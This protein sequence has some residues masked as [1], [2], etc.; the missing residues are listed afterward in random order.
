[1][2]KYNCSYLNESGDSLDESLQSVVAV[3]PEAAA[4]LY[5]ARYPEEYSGI[6][7]EWGSG[8]SQIVS[9]ISGTERTGSRVKFLFLLPLFAALLVVLC[10]E[11]S[12]GDPKIDQALK[13][14]VDLELT[15]SR[16]D[17]RRYKVG[18]SNPFSGWVKRR[19]DDSRRVAR[20]W[21]YKDGKPNG[22]YL[23]WYKSGKK[24]EYG[25]FKDGKQ[26]GL[27]TEL[28]KNGWKKREYTYKDGEFDGPHASWHENGQKEIE[29]TYW[30]V[31]NNS[32]NSLNHPSAED[33][34]GDGL[35]DG[36]YYRIGLETSWHKNGQKHREGSYD[37]GGNKDGPW[38]AWH[39]NGQK[40]IEETYKRGI[41]DGLATQYYENGNKK[42]EGT[43]KGGSLDGPYAEWHENGQKRLETTVKDGPD[44]PYTTWYENGQKAIESTWKDGKRISAKYWNRKG[45]EV[46][47]ETEAQ[48]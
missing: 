5:S 21:Q 45:E 28:R 9:N 12:T 13:E 43:F 16:R 44:G 47:T 48:E 15:E 30:A 23:E 40:A 35:L 25:T 29:G 20:L 10:G 22:L 46:E 18:E 11:K 3:T 39:A 7:V 31:R 4:A 36:I 41:L 33:S 27:W 37:K 19:Y 2:R 17:G 8:E 24:K 26:E 42:V 34:D 14:A 38:T 1:M 32:H 6:L